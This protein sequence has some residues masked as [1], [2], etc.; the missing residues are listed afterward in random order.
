MNLR[1]HALPF[2]FGT[3]F[4]VKLYFLLSQ[5][6]PFLMIQ[7]MQLYYRKYVVRNKISVLNY[8]G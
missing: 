2:P 5:C 8:L 3:G 6:I 7:S 4:N 1:M